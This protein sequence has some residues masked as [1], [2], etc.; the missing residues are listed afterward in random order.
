MS[1]SILCVSFR[2]V[3]PRL[4]IYIYGVFF[5][6]RMDDA[7]EARP[8]IG[9]CPTPSVNNDNDNDN[10]HPGDQDEGIESETWSAEKVSGRLY[11][12]HF[13][14]TCNSR[15]FE[16][17][18]V[19]YLA[20]I[21]P[22]TL[23]PM[24]VYAVARGLSAVFLSSLVGSYVDNADRLR[25]VRTSIGEWKFARALP[26]QVLRKEALKRRQKKN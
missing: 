11:V 15:V 19:L 26:G 1:L 22:G 3:L 13:L 24:S 20:T 12:S 2:L 9:P 17:G 5:S 16:F 25:V 8:F 6:I 7:E 18:A 4:Y 21:F 10:N 14:S 23:L